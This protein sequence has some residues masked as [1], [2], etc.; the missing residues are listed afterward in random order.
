MEIIAHTM[1]YRNG[2]VSSDLT[3]RNYADGD[4]EEYKRVYE[5]CFA[6]MRTAP[7]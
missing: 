2:V 3:V 6:E 7:G 1:E 4:Y 5:A